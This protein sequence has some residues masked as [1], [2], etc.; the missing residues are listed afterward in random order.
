M[1]K[2]QKSLPENLYQEVNDF[3]DFLKLKYN[4]KEQED[5]SEKLSD[6]QKKS[7]EKGISDIESGNTFSHEEA[8]QKIREYLNSKAI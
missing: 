7:I 5:W 2:R 8:K 6:K 3:L 4:K 1:Y